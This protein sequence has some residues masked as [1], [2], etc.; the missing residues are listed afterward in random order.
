MERTDSDSIDDDND[1]DDED[2]AGDAGDAGDDDDGDDH[3]PH[4]LFDKIG[5]ERLC[6][7][8]A[9]RAVGFSLSF[10]ASEAILL[11]SLTSSNYHE[12]FRV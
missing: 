2:D 8:L 6:D 7:L 11:Q 3:I 5:A 4:L 9:L 1:D 10:R 12:G